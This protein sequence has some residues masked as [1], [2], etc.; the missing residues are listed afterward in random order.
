MQ[1]INNLAAR[2]TENNPLLN[3]SELKELIVDL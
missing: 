3:V 1:E 2:C